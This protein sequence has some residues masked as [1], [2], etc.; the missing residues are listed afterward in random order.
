[1][2]SQVCNELVREL[3]YI[4]KSGCLRYIRVNYHLITRICSQ[5]HISGESVERELSSII[6]NVR[7]SRDVCGK[8][9]ESPE[10]MREDMYGS[11]YDAI[12]RSMEK[13][14][15]IYDEIRRIHRLYILSLAGIA[16]SIM[17]LA[18]SIIIASMNNIYIFVTALT[19]GFLSIASIA[20][21][22]SSLRSSTMISIASGIMLL[23]CGIQIGDAIKTAASIAV[24]AA[25]IAT[26]HRI[27]R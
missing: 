8:I 23:L 15:M 11:I 12:R 3:A 5:R 1:M 26:S 27:L 22:N 17:L 13:L 4:E 14:E 9:P 21:A 19:A 24:L 25:S 10:S 6:A 20:I 7:A 18:L 16:V 2:A